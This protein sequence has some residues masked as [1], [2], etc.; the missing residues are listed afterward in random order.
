MP[1]VPDDDALRRQF[2]GARDVRNLY[3]R[4]SGD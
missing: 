2:Y 1:S 4:V 3:P